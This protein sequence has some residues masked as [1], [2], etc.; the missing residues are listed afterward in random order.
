MLRAAGDLQDYLRNIQWANLLFDDDI[1]LA[2]VLEL[3][4]LAV[5]VITQPFIVGRNPTDAEVAE[6]FTAQGFVKSGHLKWRHPLSKCEIADAHSGN[7]IVDEELVMM[8]ID[9]QIL[10]P[11]IDVLG[12]EPAAGGDGCSVSLPAPPGADGRL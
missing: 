3:E 2:G 8:P 7:F 9:L 11:G 12:D 6:W 1:Q 5:M 4:G 10:H